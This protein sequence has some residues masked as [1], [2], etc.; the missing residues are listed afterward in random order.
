[1]NQSQLGKI[2]R[3]GFISSNFSKMNSRSSSLRKNILVSPKLLFAESLKRHLYNIYGTPLSEESKVSVHTCD[4]E[5]FLNKFWENNPPTDKY[6]CNPLSSLWKEIRKQS[7]REPLI[8]YIAVKSLDDLVEKLDYL[9]EIFNQTLKRDLLYFF[10]ELLK[11]FL[12][13]YGD[14]SIVGSFSR[15]GN[16]LDILSYDSAISM[17]REK[18]G[19]SIY[20]K[21]DK[22]LNDLYLINGEIHTNP[23]W[24]EAKKILLSLLQVKNTI[25]TIVVHPWD[26]KGSQILIHTLDVSDADMKR[27]RISTWAN[28]MNIESD[29]PHSFSHIILATSYPGLGYSIYNSKSSE[30][31][32]LGATDN[33]KKIKEIVNNRIVD[34]LSRPYI[35]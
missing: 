11:S 25:V 26:F 8:K 6:C 4:S 27:V 23:L 15:K 17:I 18:L 29:I 30:I 24:I 21:F 28:L 16:A 3:S 7:H 32:F 12:D 14:P 34:I 31:I 19:E 35:F 5:I 33:I 13:L 1:M 9:Y 22:T 10:R 20:A 2:T